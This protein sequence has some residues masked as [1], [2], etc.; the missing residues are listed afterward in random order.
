[1]SRELLK[2]STFC[3]SATSL[4]KRYRYEYFIHQMH[5]KIKI[6]SLIV[7]QTSL[8]SLTF[9]GQHLLSPLKWKEHTE[10]VCYGKGREEIED[11]QDDI[12][13][14]LSRDKV[15]IKLINERKIADER[16][17]ETARNRS[18]NWKKADHLF[19]RYAKFSEK[20]LTHFALLRVSMGKKCFFF[21]EGFSYLG[22][23]LMSVILNISSW[24]IRAT[25]SSTKF[26]HFNF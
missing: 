4:E 25:I 12:R 11:F 1:M 13:Q 22:W 8:N 5:A 16:K 17:D 24:W 6:Q 15:R 23:C 18:V 10:F 3:T 20:S 26:I 14:P 2:I 19:S 9:A 21:P 7:F